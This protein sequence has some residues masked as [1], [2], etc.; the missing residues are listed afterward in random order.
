VGPPPPGSGLRSDA[1]MEETKK[2]A[3][4]RQQ[5]DLLERKAQ[6]SCRGGGRSQTERLR[7]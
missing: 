5:R 3:L 7:G 1:I 4:Y 2:H 6:V